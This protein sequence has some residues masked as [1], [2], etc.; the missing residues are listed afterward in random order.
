[1]PCWSLSLD[2]FSIALVHPSSTLSHTQDIT[3]QSD[4][5]W[6]LASDQTEFPGAP[7]GSFFA[8]IES[9]LYGLCLR[10]GL[11]LSLCT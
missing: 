10:F 6:K 5:L 7:V 1:M 2:A 8:Y 4:A 3:W 11:S 9:F